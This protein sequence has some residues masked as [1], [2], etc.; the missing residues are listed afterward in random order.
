MIMGILT[1]L[2]V[3]ACGGPPSD[4]AK[5]E[6]GGA[7][8]ESDGPAMEAKP[9]ANIEVMEKDSSIQQ[10]IDDGGMIA[11]GAREEVPI[12]KAKSSFKFEGFKPGKS[13]IGEFMEWEG[14]LFTV[15][16]KIVGAEGFIQADSVKT[17]NEGLDGHL[18]TADFFDVKVYPTI[19]FK[20]GVVDYSG[21]Q[22]QMSGMLKFHGVENEVSF[23][24]EVTDTT[25]SANFLLDTTPFNIKYV[26]VN[27]EVRL[28]FTM[29]S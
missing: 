18:K 28:E 1:V 20:N 6:I 10:K 27:K 25:L 9:D 16:G 13:H 8:M 21:P 29:S 22:P 26:G 11:N 24:V 19:E 17:D 3:S 2:L 7:A 4:V 5:A 14:T 15:D 23:P 12:N